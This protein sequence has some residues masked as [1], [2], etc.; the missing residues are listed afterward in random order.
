MRT[1]TVAVGNRWPRLRRWNPRA[2]EAIDAVCALFPPDIQRRGIARA[3]YDFLWTLDELLKILPSDLRGLKVMDV[4]CGAGVVALA[5]RHLGASVTVVDRFDEY[6]DGLD[7]QMGSAQEIVD[8]FQRQGITVARRDV[9]A[10]GLP[11]TGGEFD[12]ITFFAVIEH[13][14]GSP[15]EILGQMRAAL[16]PGGRVVITTPNL[17]WIRTRARLLAGRSTNHPLDEWWRTPFFGHMREF[18]MPEA[19]AMLQWAGFTVERAAFNNWQHLASRIRGRQGEPDVWTTRFTLHSLER[20]VVAGALLAG[21]LIPSLRYAILLI[22]RK[23][24]AP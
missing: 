20:W 11:E 7:N 1:E 10:E 18:T 3:Y 2:Q 22:G 8:R 5:L 19:K 14:P 12:L 13:W 15:R 17:A 23:A 6:D 9:F 16:K 24:E 4:G 21:A